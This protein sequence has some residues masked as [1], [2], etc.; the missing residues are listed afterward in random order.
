MH[1]SLALYMRQ[2]A[3][4]A[5]PWDATVSPCTF[6]GSCSCTY[7]IGD[8]VLPCDTSLC[9]ADIGFAV[10]QTATSRPTAACMAGQQ[11]INK[12]GR[13]TCSHFPVWSS[14]PSPVPKPLVDRKSPGNAAPVTVMTLPSLSFARCA[15]A[16][17]LPHLTE[18]PEELHA[19][20]LRRN[21]LAAR[22]SAA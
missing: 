5:H 1:A 8:L 21:G 17:L 20:E 15:M 2:C 22:R 6:I 19:G 10:K 12:Y 9:N 3:Q 13:S 14:I 16:S 4:D 7:C 18:R 11:Q